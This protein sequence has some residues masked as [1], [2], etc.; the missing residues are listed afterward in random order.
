MPM[1]VGSVNVLAHDAFSMNYNKHSI[2]TVDTLSPQG[3]SGHHLGMWIR[4]RNVFDP[5][6]FGMEALKALPQK[7]HCIRAA[8]CHVI[9]VHIAGM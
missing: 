2:L 9:I 5:G 4:T 6:A 3:S 7:Y 8:V 1:E